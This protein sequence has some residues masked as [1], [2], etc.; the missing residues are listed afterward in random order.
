MDGVAWPEQHLVPG[1]AVVSE[2][3]LSVRT[4]IN[5]VKDGERYALACK[6]AKVLDVDGSFERRRHELSS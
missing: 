1:S 2:R 4:S 5:V 6:M 3:D